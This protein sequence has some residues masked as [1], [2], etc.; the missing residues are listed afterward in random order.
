MESLN[1]ARKGKG[2]GLSSTSEDDEDERGE[3][4]VAKAGTPR[5]DEEHMCATPIRP[6]IRSY[7]ARASLH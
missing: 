6:P 3:D 2:E 5:L 7:G 4:S 1:F